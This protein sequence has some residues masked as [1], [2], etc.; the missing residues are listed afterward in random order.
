MRLNKIVNY[1][2]IVIMT[3]FIASCGFHLRGMDGDYQFPYKTVYL[4]CDTPVIC[5]NFESAIINQ[6]LTKLVKNAESAEVTLA[7]SDEDTNRVASNYNS[8]GQ[9]AGYRLIYK[10]TAR[11]YDKKGTQTMPDIVVTAQDTINYNNSLI[12]SATQQEAQTW[13][14]LHQIAINSLIRRIVYSHPHLISTNNATE[15]K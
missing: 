10:V 3:L 4:V 12:L 1:S 15:S 9:I 14:N 5:P 8:V 7:V 13:D 2:L 11:V 6:N